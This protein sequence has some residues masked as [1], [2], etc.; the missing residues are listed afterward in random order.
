MILGEHWIGSI[1]FAL[2]SLE[3]SWVGATN[4]GFTD[5]AIPVLCLYRFHYRGT[6]DCQPDWDW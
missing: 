5:L 2:P 3:A 4:Q 1:L 6:D